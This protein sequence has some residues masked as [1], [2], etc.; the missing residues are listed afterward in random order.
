M[1]AS[2]GQ[3]GEKL[4]INLTPLLD[5]VLQLIMFFMLTVNFVRIDQVNDEVVLPVV[6]SAMPIRATTDSLVYISIGKD[7]YRMVSGKRLPPTAMSQL[8]TYIQE[9]KREL[10][11]KAKARAQRMGVKYVAAPIIVVVRAHRDASWGVIYD[12]LQECEKA[13]YNRTQLRVLKQAAVS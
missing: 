8:K 6:Q 11:N 9:R 3:G 13:G 5:L 1:S 2:V 4:E 10:E 12:T 7:D